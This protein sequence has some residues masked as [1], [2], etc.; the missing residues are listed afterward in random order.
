LPQ[1]ARSRTV[2][3]IAHDDRHSRPDRS[4]S[5]FLGAMGVVAVVTIV[6]FVIFGPPEITSIGPE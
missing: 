5:V 6:A 4:F 3:S 1:T 2:R